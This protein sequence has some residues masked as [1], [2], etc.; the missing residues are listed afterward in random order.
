MHFSPSA[1]NKHNFSLNYSIDVHDLFFIPTPPW[2]IGMF[3]LVKGKENPT[4][5]DV[6]GHKLGKGKREID[7]NWSKMVVSNWDEG[8][9]DY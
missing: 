1:S 8:I 6:V 9:G 7:M 3:D 5:N 2:A 4:C